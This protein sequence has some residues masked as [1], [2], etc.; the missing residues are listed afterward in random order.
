MPV[1]NSCLFIHIPKCAGTSLE[2]AFGIADDYPHLG[3]T[4]TKTRPNFQTLFGDG[5][6]HLSIREINTNYPQISRGAGIFKFSVIRD[7]VDRF[8]SE[9]VWRHFRFQ[10]KLQVDAAVLRVFADALRALVRLAHSNALFEDPYRGLLCREDDRDAPTLNDSARHLLPQCCFVYDRGDV[11]LDKLFLFEELPRIFQ[12]LPVACQP[13][14]PLPHRMAGSVSDELRRRISPNSEFL[15]RSVYRHDEK[16]LEGIRRSRRAG[17]D[18]A[19]VASAR[20]LAFPKLF[21]LQRP[22]PAAIVPRR[23]WTFWLQGLNNAP[24]LV[25]RCISSWA[26][27]NPRWKL[28][29]LTKGTIDNMVTLPDYTKTLALP[30]QAFSDVLRIHLLNRY[31]GVWVDATTWCVIPLDDWID[32]VAQPAGFFAYAN[33]GGHRPLA[34][35]FLAATFPNRIVG[36]WAARVNEMWKCRA[37]GVPASSE[38]L[39]DTPDPLDYFWFHSLFAELLR[40]EADFAEAWKSVPKISAHGPHRLRELGPLEPAGDECKL[41]V[42]NKLA[43]LYKLDRRLLLPENRRGLAIGLLVDQPNETQENP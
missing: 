15:I 22:E 34:S 42:Y 41:H 13:A 6:Q 36:R 39:T 37:K 18:A 26:A 8:V 21:S 1:V 35:W 14:R 33:P 5:L 11:P 9:F 20:A 23:I 4:I 30:V 7:P 38:P 12:L 25:K 19:P 16:L 32:R 31:G 24:P 29:V 17:T 28:T 10:E 43:N 2:V 3:L 40:D 27:K